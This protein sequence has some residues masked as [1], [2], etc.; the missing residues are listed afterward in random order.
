LNGLHA[1]GNSENTSR[2]GGR[3]LDVLVRLLLLLGCKCC[4]P[5]SS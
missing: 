1:Q 5:H 4:D 3:K 2:G